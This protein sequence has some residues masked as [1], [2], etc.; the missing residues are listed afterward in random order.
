MVRVKLAVK[1]LLSQKTSLFSELRKI[2]FFVYVKYYFFLYL[3]VSHVFKELQFGP[4]L[5]L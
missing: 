4:I 5:S 3:D 1:L 2:A